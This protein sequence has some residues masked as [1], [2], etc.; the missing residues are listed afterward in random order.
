M[1]AEKAMCLARNNK[2]VYEAHMACS[3]QLCDVMP[4]NTRGM[5]WGEYSHEMC[6]GVLLL[7]VLADA[8]EPVSPSIPHSDCLSQA[9]E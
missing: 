1:T 3:M 4:E 6:M 5:S 8:H 9:C 2:H 7:T